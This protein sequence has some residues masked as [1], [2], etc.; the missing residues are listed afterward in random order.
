MRAARP[1]N[2]P[3]SA[4]APVNPGEC[5]AALP[6]LPDLWHAVGWSAGLV[7][8]HLGATPR[9]VAELAARTGKARTTVAAACR[10]LAAHGLARR[11]GR[12]W[13]R[14]LESPP[15][16]R[17]RLGVD[18]A[19][20]RRREAVEEERR[21]WEARGRKAPPQRAA[22]YGL[23]RGDGRRHQDQGVEGGT[24]P[25]GWVLGNG[26]FPWICD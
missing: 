7:Y 23:R 5:G 20:A 24:D 15:L 21:A 2:A 3:N 14:G 18:R 26:R 6:V 4:G 1:D 10:A 11:S 13:V 17:Q 12:G 19:T 9:T 8:E 16:V 25:V 22:I